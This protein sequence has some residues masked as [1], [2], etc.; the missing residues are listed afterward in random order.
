MIV[1]SAVAHFA[2]KDGQHG[3]FQGGSRRRRAEKVAREV[4]NSSRETAKGGSFLVGCATSSQISFRMYG[5]ANRFTDLM[6]R[7][8]GPNKSSKISQRSIILWSYNRADGAPLLSAS[9]GLRRSSSCYATSFYSTFVL[10]LGC[11]K[12]FIH[13]L[14]S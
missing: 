3:H 4:P 9:V 13:F 12:M 10:S 1:T 11:I 14:P 2:T 8:D 7:I 6:A 5:H